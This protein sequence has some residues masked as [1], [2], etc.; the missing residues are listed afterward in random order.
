MTSRV[1]TGTTDTSYDPM[2][3]H[4]Q[5]IDGPNNK[6]DGN[7][8]EEN[9]TISGPDSSG[10]ITNVF[11]KHYSLGHGYYGS[12]DVN[13]WSRMDVYGSNWAWDAIQEFGESVTYFCNSGTADATY[14]PAHY[15]NEVDFGGY[16]SD[17]PQAAYNP[18]KATRTAFLLSTN[19]TAAQNTSRA[20]WVASTS[21]WKYQQVIVKDS[22]GKPWIFYALP[23][24]YTVGGDSNA[25]SATS[26]S[27]APTWV[28]AAGSTVTDGGLTWYCEG[29]F[30]YDI[31]AL[32]RVSG[33]NDPST[34]YIERIGTLIEESND[35]IYNAVFDMS[36]AQFDPSVAYKVFG[37]LQ[38]DMYLDMTADGTK[39]GQNNHLLGYDG[40]S[41]ALVYKVNGVNNL[42][43]DDEGN[44]SFGANSS[45]G[46]I[47]LQVG[48]Q[49]AKNVAFID[50]FA[51][52]DSNASARILS[53]SSLLEFLYSDASFEQA[54]HVGTSLYLG[55]MTKAAILALA[56]PT[57]GQK[58]FDSDDHEEVTYRCP[59]TTTC[60][61]F[62]VQYG[63]ALS[64]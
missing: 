45:A 4:R 50:L 30:T 34:G 52:G 42:R 22:S 33:G 32:I 14:C 44:A 7:N 37:R 23:T 24:G 60:G 58:V 35:Y 27:T 57:E 54:V 55:V 5:Y 17:D 6:H 40:T 18:D 53:S 10:Y 20:S 8:T 29:P 61:W 43:I 9:I 56:S 63:T 38:K 64:D 2:V 36:T 21:F 13:H 47:G 3:S 26:G 28:F 51:N 12:F 39:A 25:S 16:G 41:N 62:P 15:I 1:S 19:T 46:G 11:D 59:T 31:G 49:V 48:S